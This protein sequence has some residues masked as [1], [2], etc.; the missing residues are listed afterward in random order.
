MQM[1]ASVL[2]NRIA[3]LSEQKRAQLCENIYHSTG[4]LLAFVKEFLANSAADH[5]FELRTEIVDIAGIVSRVAQDYDEAALRKNLK[6]HCEIPPEPLNALVDHTATTQVFDNLVSN[7]VKFSP[8]DREIH[9]V[10][11][12]TGEHIECRVRD[13]GPGFSEE[14]KARMFRRYGRLSARPTG[15]EPSTGLGL[16]IVKKLV[17]AMKGDLTCDSAPDQGATFTVRLPRCNSN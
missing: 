6:I 14:D 1:S 9:L 3:Q 8:P 12:A 13:H 17:Q 16:S 2:R 4:Q 5:G 11:C 15:G 7:A 10:L